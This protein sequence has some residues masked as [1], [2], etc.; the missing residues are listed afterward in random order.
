MK[1]YVIIFVLSIVCSTNIIG[2]VYEAPLRS[3][4]PSSLSVYCLGIYKMGS[5]NY[6]HYESLSLP[7]RLTESNYFSTSSG[8][9]HFF[10]YSKR[11][12]R[13][14]FYTDN[15]IGFYLPSDDILEK[16][17]FN[18][19]NDNNVRKIDLKEVPPVLDEIKKQLDEKYERKN[20][21][22]KEKNRLQREK[23]I[24]DSISAVQKKLAGMEE[25]RKEH[26]WHDL[27]LSKDYKLECKFCD[28]SHYQDK[29]N[30]MSISADTIYYLKEDPDLSILG[31]NHF[32]I[33]Y[34]ALTNSFKND[35][36]F[37][38]YVNIW[39]DSLANHNSFKNQDAAIINLINYNEFLQNVC[40]TAPYGYIQRWGWHLNSAD[41]IEPNFSYYNT[42]K[43]TIKYIDFYFSVYNAVGDR[44]YLK[45]NKSYIGNVR[46]VG[47]VEQFESGSWNWDRATHY[48]SSD[49]SEMRIIKL[50]ITYM[51][52]TIKTI[53][54]DSII[55][56]D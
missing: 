56:G 51:D 36:N 15:I 53:P 21:S 34:S 13:Y 1:K 32:A 6:Y 47:P 7:E 14:Y 4:I 54:K 8:K 23:Q 26:S 50:V 22:I 27:K 10:C 17:L 24:Q 31:I 20:D 33:H 29:Y 5:D 49:A 25:Y 39:R 12:K 48:T 2:Q 18:A 40:K 16:E 41:G 19:M 3:R 38:D 43:K 9:E 44:C 52:G 11:A 46:G 35:P 37:I 55:Y 45:Y 42:S 30:I 28:R